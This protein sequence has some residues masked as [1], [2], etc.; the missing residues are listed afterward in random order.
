[1]LSP[2]NANTLPDRAGEKNRSQKTENRKQKTEARSQSMPVSVYQ[3][4]K[5][6]ILSNLGTKKLAVNYVKIAIQ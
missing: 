4:Q 5:P 1:M 2:K 6:D 3:C